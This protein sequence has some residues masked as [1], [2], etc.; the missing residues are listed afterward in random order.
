MGLYIPLIVVNAGG[1]YKKTACVNRIN[2]ALLLKA[3]LTL[4]FGRQV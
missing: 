3:A 1:R 4:A 2:G